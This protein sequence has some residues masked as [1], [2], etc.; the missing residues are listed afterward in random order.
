[1]RLHHFT[2]LACL[3]LPATALAAAPGGSGF[4]VEHLR[5]AGTESRFIADD[6]SV[7]TIDCSGDL[8]LAGGGIHAGSSISLSSGGALSLE[9]LTLWAPVVRLTGEQVTFGA[10]SVI[11]VSGGRIV[12][13]ARDINLQVRDIPRPG[14]P[15]LILDGGGD[16]TLRTPGDPFLRPRDTGGDIRLSEG[17]GI[18]TA[19]GGGSSIPTLLTPVPEPETWAMLLAGL[20]LLAA[21]LRHR[22]ADTGRQSAAQP[23]ASR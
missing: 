9:H 19:G 18:V 4:A 15:D 7:V 22:Q 20:L 6:L 21:R 23:L 8:T 14:H 5:C 3:L 13:D 10:G 17:G 1:M 2:L 12:L 16:V 11:H